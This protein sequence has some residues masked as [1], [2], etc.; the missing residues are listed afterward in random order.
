MATIT[1]PKAL[2]IENVAGRPRAELDFTITPT[3]TAGS[4]TLDSIASTTL[5]SQPEGE[6]RQFAL[7]FTARSTPT[8]IALSFIP[9]RC[10]QH[11][12][13]EDKIGTL[14][15]FRVTVGSFHDALFTYP[16]SNE[17][18]VAL[19]KYVARYCGW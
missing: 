10:E 5:L 15:P 2:R 3:G 12:V 13:A 1:P 17:L 14:I 6:L 7:A 9:A 18:K 16:L 8:M 19:Y 11:L 4:A